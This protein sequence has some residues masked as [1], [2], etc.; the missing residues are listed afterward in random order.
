MVDF[1]IIDNPEQKY[2]VQVVD[3]VGCLWL[4]FFFF[5]DL[6]RLGEPRVRLAAQR[7]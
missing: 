2:W 6:T 1:T 5:A 7:P 3:Y 4:E